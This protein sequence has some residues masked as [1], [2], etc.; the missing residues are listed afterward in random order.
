MCSYK[1]SSEARYFADQAG[2]WQI[3]ATPGSEGNKVMRQ[4]V[5]QRPICWS[6]DYSPYTII[7]DSKWTSVS[8][9]ADV[10][11][12]SST[13]GMAFVAARLGVC[14]MPQGVF[15]GVDAT[16]QRW[17]LFTNITGSGLAQELTWAISNETW[18]VRE[19]QNK[20]M[21]LL[22]VAIVGVVVCQCVHTQ[23]QRLMVALMSQWLSRHQVHTA[24]GHQ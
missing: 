12:E 11:I 17:V 21:L 23:H 18:C 2:S 4:N 6:G 24:T 7:G 5:P 16:R 15:F 3:E 9:S 14:C 13:G 19:G 20:C 22:C 1:V 10:F 8:V